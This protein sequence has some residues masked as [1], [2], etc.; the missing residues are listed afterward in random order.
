MLAQPVQPGAHHLHGDALIVA[1]DHVE[2]VVGDQLDGLDLAHGTD[3][4]GAM[5]PML[6][7]P[8]CS[9]Q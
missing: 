5:A 1:V 4:R 3:R 6:N 9:D 7:T 8:L 2:D